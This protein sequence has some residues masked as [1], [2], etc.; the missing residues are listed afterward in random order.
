MYALGLQMTL[1][2]NA[3]TTLARAKTE[4]GIPPGDTS[5]DNLIEKYITAATQF[6]ETY[7][8]RK[9]KRAEYTH[10]L[11]GNDTPSIPLLQ[12]PI[13]K[14][15][16]VYIDDDWAFAV[17][18]LLAS[19]EYDTQFDCLLVRKVGYFPNKPR[20]IKVQYF[21]GYDII[22][23]D[24]EEACLLM[25][26]WIYG[27]KSSETI[28]VTSKSKVGDS[29]TFDANIPPLVKALLDPMKRDT[30]VKAQLSSPI[31]GG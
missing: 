8:N 25:V 19:S 14:P 13:E 4:I 15:S 21:A 17:A 26:V 28:G 23:A 3:L 1:G 20:N 30:W 12:F 9:I 18:S 27:I 22:P 11:T 31:S 7:L 6:I 10:Y 29:V 24:I 16:A 5:Q 2:T